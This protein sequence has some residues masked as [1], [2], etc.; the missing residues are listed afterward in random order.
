VKSRGLGIAVRIADGNKR[1]LH[2]ATVNVLQRL[3]LIDERSP[4][5]AEVEPTLR[6]FRGTEVGGVRAVFSIGSMA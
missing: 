6:N 2:V 1:A 5:A 4:L 3:G